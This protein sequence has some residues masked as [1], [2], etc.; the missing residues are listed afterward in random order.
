M[1]KTLQAH[2]PPSDASNPL[3]FSVSYLLLSN[4]RTAAAPQT[5]GSDP[6]DTAGT[7]PEMFMLPLP[8][9]L[10]GDQYR[11]KLSYFHPMAFD[12]MQGKYVLRL[13]TTVP[14]VSVTCC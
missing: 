9:G 4:F 13:P 7:D 14:A 12:V 6:E 3:I 8:P 1:R 2:T 11:V 10:P 5:A